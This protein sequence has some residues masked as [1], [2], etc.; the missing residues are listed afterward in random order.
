MF[1]KHL[2]SNICGI[3]HFSLDSNVQHFSTLS[4]HLLHKFIFIIHTWTVFPSL[5]TKVPGPYGPGGVPISGLTMFQH[6][7]KAV[8]DSAHQE[9]KQRQDQGDLDRRPHFNTRSPTIMDRDGRKR[10][11]YTHFIFF[12]PISPKCHRQHCLEDYKLLMFFSVS[13]TCTKVHILC[14]LLCNVAQNGAE[15]KQSKS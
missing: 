3:L 1:A 9:E 2:N 4:D 14:A 5:I 7:I 12:A 10:K 15:K 6:Q 8:H 13:C 11:N